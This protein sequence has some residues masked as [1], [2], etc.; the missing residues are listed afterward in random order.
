MLGHC[1]QLPPSR[2]ATTSSPPRLAVHIEFSAPSTPSAA[3]DVGY[4]TEPGGGS[5]PPKPCWAVALIGGSDCEYGGGG[6]CW[7]EVTQE[8]SG[9]RRLAVLAMNCDGGGCWLVDVGGAVN[10]PGDVRDGRLGEAVE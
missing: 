4:A 7:C 6:A 2:K 3:G 10:A 1:S 9:C 8:L 5:I